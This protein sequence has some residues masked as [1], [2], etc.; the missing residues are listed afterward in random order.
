MEMNCP[1][2]AYDKE[3]TLPLVIKK[4]FAAKLMYDQI[5]IEQLRDILSRAAFALQREDGASVFLK[6]L[7]S[8]CLSGGRREAVDTFAL[9][10]FGMWGTEFK[11]VYDKKLLLT[12]LLTA[13]FNHSL[14]TQ[15]DIGGANELLFHDLCERGGINATCFRDVSHTQR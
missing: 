10:D 7:Y 15:Y 11:L 13:K 8:F 14:F 3:S 2:E 4:Y 1:G 9:L 5:I 6:D 12:Q